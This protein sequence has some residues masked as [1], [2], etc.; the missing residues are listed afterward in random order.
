MSSFL[1]STSYFK[2]GIIMKI[3]KKR[4]SLFVPAFLYNR[5]DT[6]AKVYG[7]TKTTIVQNALL[8]YYRAIDSKY[9][10]RP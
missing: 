9:N 3:E 7:V 1:S 2:G 8:S 6:D 5:L 10:N 4:I